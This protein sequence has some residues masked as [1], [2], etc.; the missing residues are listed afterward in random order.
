MKSRVD[1]FIWSV[2]LAKTR[3]KATELINKG[4][5]RVNNDR[6]KPSK[7]IKCGDIITVV[8]HNAQLSYKVL[9]L[10]E[11]R[12]GAKL[13][14]NFIQEVTPAEE[15]EKIKL[16]NSAQKVY[17]DNGSGKPTKKDRRDLDEFIE[18]WSEL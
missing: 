18:K 9:G 11:R 13:V 4:K 2:R 10:L 12:V 1:K 14:E 7:E 17:R 8:V 5:I 3:S 15:I 6:I 16:Y